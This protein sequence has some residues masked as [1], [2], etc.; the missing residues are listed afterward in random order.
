MVPGHNNPKDFQR[1]LDA[2]DQQRLADASD[3]QAKVRVPCLLQSRTPSWQGPVAED[4]TVHIS[5]LSRFSLLR[6]INQVGAL[7]ATP[8]M[9]KKRH[10]DVRSSLVQ[11]LSR[12]YCHTP[13]E[14]SR[15]TL[16]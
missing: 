4:Q 11:I 6:E 9:R 12:L 2:Y 8:C 3:L 16:L 10:I 1:R 14:L 7:S 5:L 13:Q 15:A